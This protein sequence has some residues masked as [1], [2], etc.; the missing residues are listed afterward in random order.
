MTKEEF[1]EMIRNKNKTA[2]E[3][4]VISIESLDSLCRNGMISSKRI[5]GQIMFKAEKIYRYLY[6]I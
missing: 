5:N 1:I 3:L 6:E 4:R 2:I